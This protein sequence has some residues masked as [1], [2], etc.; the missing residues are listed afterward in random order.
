MIH[1][2]VKIYIK[3]LR[4]G[5]EAVDWNPPASNWFE[6]SRAFNFSDSFVSD[7][8]YTYMYSVKVGEANMYLSISFPD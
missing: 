8:P 2:L 7:R 4:W 5:D 6:I 1:L 3:K